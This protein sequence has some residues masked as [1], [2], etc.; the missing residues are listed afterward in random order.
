[1]RERPV[2][3]LLAFVA[4][5]CATDEATPNEPRDA[6]AEVAA[7]DG[8]RGSS[9]AGGAGIEAAAAGTGAAGAPVSDARAGSGGFSD[10]AFDAPADVQH[11]PVTD[12]ACDAVEQQHP[13]SGSAHLPCN[14]ALT[15]SSNPPSSGDHYPTWAAFKAYSAPVPRG[16]LVHALEHGAVVIAYHCPS[17]CAAEVAEAQAA[18]ELLPIEPLCA[19]TGALRRV[20]LVPDP[21]LD[22]RW[23]AS[24]WGF[25]LRAGCF[26]AVAFSRFVTDHLGDAPEN[27]CSPGWDFQPDGGA[28]QFPSGC[29]A[30]DASAD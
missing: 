4:A 22:V 7:M 17:G 12:A 19:S 13:I 10:A 9:G 18:I 29:G 3:F 5:G 8:D 15:H 27:F 30:R 20:I 26:D 21:L 11:E 24:A 28:L 25:T 14:G 23:A 16:Y 2:T 6:S 1:M